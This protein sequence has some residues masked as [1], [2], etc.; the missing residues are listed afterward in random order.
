VYQKDLGAASAA[1]ARQMTRF[2]QDKSWRP[3]EE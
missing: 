2:N 3:V 1:L